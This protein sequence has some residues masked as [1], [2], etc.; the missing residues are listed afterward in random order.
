MPRGVKSGNVSSKLT[1]GKRKAAHQI[2]GTYAEWCRVREDMKAAGMT[3]KAAEEEASRVV[4]VREETLAKVQE[5]TRLYHLAQAEEK[6]NI[7]ERLERLRV[8]EE[9]AQVE[10]QERYSQGELVGESGN[11]TLDWIYAN[12]DVKE[13]PCPPR[14]G[15]WSQLEYFRSN[16]SEFSRLYWQAVFRKKGIVPSDPEPAPANRTAEQLLAE[17]EGK[18]RA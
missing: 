2:Q 1:K 18:E 6:A 17:I 13:P 3:Q 11:S 8:L 15:D 12:M 7:A 4:P 9:K 16:R 5:Q 10:A 14:R